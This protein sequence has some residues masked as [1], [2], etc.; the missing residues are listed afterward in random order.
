LEPVDSAK[1]ATHMAPFFHSSGGR[2]AETGRIGE[3]VAKL[4]LLQLLFG[5]VEAARE[6]THVLA[7]AHQKFSGF[8]F[9]DG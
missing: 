9:L 3:V 7:V 6:E 1:S 2:F 5:E 4:H 8:D